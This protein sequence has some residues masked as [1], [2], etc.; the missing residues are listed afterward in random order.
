MENTFSKPNIKFPMFP[1]I[2]SYI[3]YAYNKVECYSDFV[4][5]ISICF[6]EAE[7]TK[8]DVKKQAYTSIAESLY[9]VETNISYSSKKLELNIEKL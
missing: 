4:D 3:E 8:N 2:Y 7:R 6:N 9:S 5:F 1:V